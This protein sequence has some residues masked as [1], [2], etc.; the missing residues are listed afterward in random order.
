MT[1]TEI[2][3]QVA[4]SYKLQDSMLTA[5]YL[6]QTPDERKGAKTIYDNAWGFDQMDAPIL[7]Q[8]AR[9]AMRGLELSKQER[10]ECEVRLG[11][12]AVQFADYLSA[13]VYPGF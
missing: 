1:T 2:R 10:R 8:V 12:Y 3:D 11:K 13:D 4:R 9:K 6:C 7:T 5:L